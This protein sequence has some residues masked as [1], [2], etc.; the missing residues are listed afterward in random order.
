[1][2]NLL[3]NK[4]DRNA[5]FVF[6]TYPTIL[7]AIDTMKNSDGSRF[8]SPG[9][10]DLIVIDEAHRSIF[11]KYRAIFEYFDACL[12]GLTATPKKT[13]HQSTYEFFDMKNNMPTDV[14]EYDEAIN[15]DHVLVP[16]YLI[17]TATRIPDDGI[18]YEKLDEEEREE[19]EDEFCEDEGMPE[20]IPP[21]NINKYIFNIDTVDKMISDLMN[22]G[23]KHKNGNHVG[24]TIIFAQNKRHAK[25]IVERFDKLYPQYK[26]AFCKLVICDEP[27][28]EKNLDDFKKPDE[29]PFITVTVDMLETGVDVPEI[30]NLVFAKKVYS[31]I[32]FDQMIGRGTRLC[33]NLLGEGEDKREFYV[34]DYMRNFQFFDEHPKGK[35][36]GMTV[37]PVTARFVRRVQLIRLL[38]DL[39]Y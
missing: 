39:V 16:F 33:N 13:V 12:L 22:N 2:C 19:Y 36:P 17:E 24:K 15:K 21:E 6:S 1:M 20:H 18:T 34:F 3:L 23:I 5:K 8:F 29:C 35:E 31:R 14:Y 37:A 38:Q 25:F 4:E 26:G 11:N 32:K 7:N 28:A 30:T 27:Y 10:F 9:H